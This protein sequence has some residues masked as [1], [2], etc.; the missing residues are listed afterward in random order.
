MGL[1]DTATRGILPKSQIIVIYGPNGV[2]KTTLATAFSQSLIADLED[3][4]NHIT[5]TT[6]ISSNKL[7]TYDDLLLLIEEVKKSTFKTFVV[8]SLESLETLI[9]TKIKKDNKVESIEDIPY[10]KG[11]VYTREEFERF[12]R[13]MHQL[14]DDNGMDVILVGH[15]VTKAYTDPNANVTYDRQ[16]LRTND[17]VASIV[18]DLSDCI[19]YIT[20]KVDTVSQKN[21]DKVKAYGDGER[22]IYTQ[23]RPGFDAKSRYP[24]AFEI[25]F[26]LDVTPIT[27]IVELLKPKSPEDLAQT[28]RDLLMR[29]T[30]EMR[31]KEIAAKMDKVIDNPTQLEK[32]KNKLL[33]L[34]K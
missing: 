3:G 7:T 23:W 4:S 28:C 29:I 27:E 1:I 17:K 8:D 19:L 6:R 5:N 11:M 21:K 33:E 16:V 24:I 14:R 30:D 13:L 9:Q 2:G 20:Y 32:F 31:R 12:M 18:K 10:G 26:N 22:I 15:S 34:V 25:P